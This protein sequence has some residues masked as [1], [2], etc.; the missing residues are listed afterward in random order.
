MKSYQN[1]LL[2]Q[3]LYRLKAIG[4][5]YV[6]PFSLNEAN[7]F[8]QAQT[9]LELE[10]ITSK[11]RL[12][13]LSKSRKQVMSGFGNPNAEIMFVDFSVSAAQDSSNSYY[14]GRSGEVLSNMIENVLKISTSQCYITHCVKCKPLGANRPTPSEYNSCSSYLFSQFDFISPKIIVTLGEDAYAY[15]TQDRDSFQNVRGH[16]IDFRGTKL[17]PIY[18]PAHLL[19]N[20]D[21]KKVALRDLYT[22]KSYLNS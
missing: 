22:I 17:I 3:N 10:Q 4:Y 14:S 19:K 5:E 11:C 6:D 15:L 12:C 18:H 2:L 8:T 1:L 16:L 13:D 7:D 21:L 9:L 20:P